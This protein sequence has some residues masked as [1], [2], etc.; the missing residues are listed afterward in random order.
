MAAVAT[1]PPVP[2]TPAIAAAA[3]TGPAA[4]EMETA[5]PIAITGTQLR[6]TT[7]L[8]TT[9]TCTRSGMARSTV[10]GTEMM[11]IY[12]QPQQL[13]RGCCHQVREASIHT[14]CSRP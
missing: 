8:T 10:E 1:A 3:D 2:A 6:T 13:A 9:R 7:G 4:Q 11:S 12:N 14:P 5:C